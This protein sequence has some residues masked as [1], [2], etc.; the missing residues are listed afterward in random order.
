MS[1]VEGRCRCKFVK[2]CVFFLVVLV[3]K[4]ELG[5]QKRNVEG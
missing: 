1:K 2:Y 4:P 3:P 5:N